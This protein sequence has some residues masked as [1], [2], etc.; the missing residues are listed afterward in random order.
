LP[1]TRGVG[2]D[3]KPQIFSQCESGT[4]AMKNRAT[5]VD[6]FLAFV[7]TFVITLA[8]WPPTAPRQ[9]IHCNQPGGD[10]ISYSL[11]IDDPAID[12]LRAKIDRW[13][14]LESDRR[15]V[16]A[17]WQLQLADFYENKSRQQKSQQAAASPKLLSTPLDA[18]PMVAYL[19][20][21]VA[22][23]SYEEPVDS[24][25]TN[26]AAA[27]ESNGSSTESGK[28]IGSL[29]SDPDANTDSNAHTAIDDAEYWASIR[30]QAQATINAAEA[31]RENVPVVLESA[32][33]HAWPQ[34]AFHT[35]FLFG[36]AAA[37]GYKHWLRKAP[38][39]PERS[40]EKQPTKVLVRIG[41]F[42][43]VVL[44]SVICSL[45]VWF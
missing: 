3:V 4:D 30:R 41:S 5:D 26:S 9:I 45:A 14:S 44:F 32:P 7:A 36:L 23:A 1:T 35:A 12:N 25:E 34:L 16:T 10:W 43:G 18:K 6:L 37:C 31:R 8:L 24:T 29:H 22:V 2:P 39:A 13:T 20:D 40:F 15:Y 38:I 11:P 21:S 42:T 17:K 33:R 28:L 27:A 19:T